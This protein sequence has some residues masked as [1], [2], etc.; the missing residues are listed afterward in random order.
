LQEAPAAEPPRRSQR[1]RKL[2]IPNDYEVY[3]C[4]EIHIEGDP[5]SYEEAMSCSDASKWQEA[6]DD[7]MKSMSTNRVWDIEEIPK[8]PE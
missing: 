3:N 8:E 1:V 2:A 7:A 5:S 4:E 6:M